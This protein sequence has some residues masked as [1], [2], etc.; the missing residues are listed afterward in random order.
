M[1]MAFIDLT[2]KWSFDTKLIQI[3][4]LISNEKSKQ[5][6]KFSQNSSEKLKG[7]AYAFVLFAEYLSDFF[8]IHN[9]ALRIGIVGLKI[10]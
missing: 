10:I 2:S 5:S 9:Q 1:V 4:N 8:T 6:S 3:P 7:L